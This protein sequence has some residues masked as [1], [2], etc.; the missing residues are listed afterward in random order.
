M[1]SHGRHT[2]CVLNLHHLVCDTIEVSYCLEQACKF[3]HGCTLT[4]HLRNLMESLQQGAD[5]GR[6]AHLGNVHS[7]VLDAECRKL[8]RTKEALQQG[9]AL[10]TAPVCL[11]CRMV[12]N[13]TL[14]AGSDVKCRQLRDA[15][16]VLQQRASAGDRARL[17]VMQ[18]RAALQSAAQPS[19][20]RS[21][22]AAVE[23]QQHAALL[24]SAMD[25]ASEVRGSKA[26]PPTM[27]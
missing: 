23:E 6:C 19:S 17:L 10:V 24:Q 12:P 25:A 26:S 21:D 16:E 13:K 11:V 1:H 8:C 5:T 7:T 2:S 3:Q 15:M 27:A 14:T 22:V 9:L 18:S 20:G 4:G